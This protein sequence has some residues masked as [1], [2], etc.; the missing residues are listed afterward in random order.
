M[1][2]LKNYQNITQGDIYITPKTVNEESEPAN[3]LCGPFRI[4]YHVFG[5]TTSGS[6]TIRRTDVIY[7][8]RTCF[9]GQHIKMYIAKNGDDEIELYDTEKDPDFIGKKQKIP[10][11]NGTVGMYSHDMA[12]HIKNFNITLNNKNAIS[13]STTHTVKYSSPAIPVHINTEYNLNDFNFGFSQKNLVNGRQIKWSCEEADIVLKNNTFKVKKQGVYTLYGEYQKRVK[14]FFIVSKTDKAGNF[15]LFSYEFKNW[16]KEDNPFTVEQFF[17]RLPLK[18]VKLIESGPFKD[19]LEIT[20]NA[21]PF[22]LRLNSDIIKHFADYTLSCEIFTTDNYFFVYKRMG[23][24]TRLNQ[25]N[26]PIAKSD[27]CAAAYSQPAGAIITVSDYKLITRPNT[28]TCKKAQADMLSALPK[29]DTK[30]NCIIPANTGRCFYLPPNSEFYFKANNANW[31]YVWI[32][33]DTNIEIPDL[34]YNMIFTLPDADK[35]F[36]KAKN[37][38]NPKE[39]FDIINSLLIACDNATKNQEDASALSISS[40]IKAFLDKNGNNNWN[41]ITVE[42]IAAKFGFNSKY[43]STVFKN[44]TGMTLQQYLIS[45]KLAT[46][47]NLLR[48]ENRTIHRTA[49]MLGYKSPDSYI[50]AFKKEFGQTPTQYIKSLKRQ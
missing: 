19:F 41:T 28:R 18:N 1:D 7:N 33:F 30:S 16:N 23:F 47:K 49:E 43:L 34:A 17:D 38:K 12:I 50:F 2:D 37:T 45:K 21:I 31:K 26:R 15:V 3:S 29:R 35:T 20:N 14:K 48:V 46:S 36:E 40:K 22:V 39:L 8:L 6:G 5:F 4:P 24:I 44:E 42:T 9:N 27:F 10:T 32:G 25:K 11:G 13:P